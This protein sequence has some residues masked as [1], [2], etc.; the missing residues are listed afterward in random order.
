MNPQTQNMT[1]SA[2]RRL[3]LETKAVNQAL[4]VPRQNAQAIVLYDQ[5]QKTSPPGQGKSRNARRKRNRQRG[6]QQGNQYVWNR[7]GGDY[8]LSLRDPENYPGVR[9]PDSVTFPSNTFQLTREG[10]GA[11]TGTGD[12]YCVW[13]CPFLGSGA[14]VFPIYEGPNNTPLGSYNITGRDWAQRATMVGLIDQVR[15]VSASITVEFVGNTIEDGGTLCVGILPRSAAGPGSTVVDFSQAIGQS[16]T[17]TVPFRNG[18]YV[19][20]KPQDNSDLEYVSATQSVAPAA[21][22]VF[23]PQIFICS[24]GMTALKSSFRWKVVANFEAIP[25]S[26]TVNLLAPQTSPANPKQLETALNWAAQSFSNMGMMFGE[27]VSPFIQPGVS[28]FAQ[29]A[30]PRIGAAAANAMFA[31]NRRN[32]RLQ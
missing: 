17:K 18:A 11:T 28:A 6:G 1:K 9:I 8:L 2:R 4:G 26:D 25:T 22:S 5:S 32:L 24:S 3:K 19:T 31:G 29:A 30:A 20:W 14:G 10:V 21:N 23:W 16:F 13:L 27:Y 12:G 15:P 7:N